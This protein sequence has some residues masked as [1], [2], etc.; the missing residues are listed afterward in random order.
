LSAYPWRDFMFGSTLGA[1]GSPLMV[2]LKLSTADKQPLPS[3][4]RMDRAWV[5]FGEEAWE[6]S[7]LRDRLVD[8]DYD[9]SAWIN[10]A[11]LSACQTTLRDGPR[12]GP[13][14]SVDVVVRFTDR[15]GK[16]HFLQA[17]NQNIVGT[18]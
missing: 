13:G 9:K 14:V 4:I 5:L 15:E 11:N 1:N 6:V 10:C 8:R 3:G 16:H 17:P 7:Y 18:N 2:A 12:W